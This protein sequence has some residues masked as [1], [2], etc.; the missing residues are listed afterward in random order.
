MSKWLY[1]LRRLF[2]RPT[3]TIRHG[4]GNIH[5]I[6]DEDIALS[7]DAQAFLFVDENSNYLTAI[8]GGIE[9]DPDTA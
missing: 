6:G 3:L 8:R 7:S 1:W 5:V 4:V 9:D 2:H